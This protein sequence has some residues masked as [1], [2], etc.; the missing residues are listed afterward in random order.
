MKAQFPKI[1]PMVN[2]IKLALLTPGQT[3]G[4]D[5]AISEN[6]YKATL[7]CSQKDSF[8]FVIPKAQFLRS[9]GKNQND[10]AWKLL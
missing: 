5:D 1:K 10:I 7:T 2:Q 9:F 6:N 3:F 4:D 8:I